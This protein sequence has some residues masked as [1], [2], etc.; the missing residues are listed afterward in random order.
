MT[1]EHEVRTA[2]LILR[3]PDP[4]A[5]LAETHAVFSDPA[6]WTHA[7]EYCHT[8]PQQTLDWL[9]RAAV[10]WDTDGLSYWVAR[11][12]DTG[13]F[14]GVAGVQR[15]A[16][17]A[18]NVMYRFDT[19]QQGRGYATEAGRAGLDAAAALDP[20]VPAIAWIRPHHE[21]SQRVALRLGLINQGLRCDASDGVARLAFAD[22][23]LGDQ[24][25]APVS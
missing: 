23:P 3:R 10:R 22:R 25:G 18:W 9:A 7:P 17:G 21:V 12:P 20:S 1:V 24:Y 13:T 15:Q 19:A 4:E 11:L 5:D 14:A 6:S 8:D 2:R 16:S